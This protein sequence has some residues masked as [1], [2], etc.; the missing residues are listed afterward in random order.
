M[1]NPWPAVVASVSIFALSASA[2]DNQPP[3]VQGTT[4]D[5]DSELSEAERTRRAQVIARVGEIEITV[6]SVEDSLNAQPEFMRSR[7]RD[8]NEIRSYIEQQVRFEL[9]ARAAAEA[10]YD[11][12]P[13][14]VRAARQ[15]AVQVLIRREF[16][17]SMTADSIPE[18]DLRTYYDEHP[19]EFHRPELRRASHIL[20]NQREDAVRLI[21][22][23]RDED[24]RAFRQA[25]ERH[26][27]DVET[28]M[29]GGDL[30][31][32]DSEGRPRNRRETQV[33]EALVRGAFD[34]DEIGDVASEPI[35]VG[36][37]WS[38]MKLTGLR[39]AV[40]RPFERAAPGIRQRLW[41]ERRTAAM[42]QFVA[43]LRERAGVEVHDERMEGIEI[44]RET[45]ESSEA[46]PHLPSV[47]GTS[48]QGPEKRPAPP[49]R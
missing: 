1:R 20:V 38:V 34:L 31:F 12:Q 41:R 22:E 10:D 48:P 3:S 15:Q 47:P 28:R 36:E 4:G 44:E 45:P 14:V 17:D 25:A 23:L 42:D 18:A 8:P 26:S 43:Q 7:Y 27:L 16:D 5:G 2:Q 19:E 9:L 21:G 13:D 30:R 6:G 46:T 24:T 49:L 11:E 37:R 39:R 40:E 29:R 32:F 33:D 35:Q